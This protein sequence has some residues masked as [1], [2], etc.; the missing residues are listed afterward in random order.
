MNKSVVFTFRGKLASAD[1]AALQLR[2]EESVRALGLSAESGVQARFESDG[3]GV[4]EVTNVPQELDESVRE[5]VS[6]QI[7][8][9]HDAVI[10]E[11]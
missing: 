6:A 1:V 7:T 4:I 8:A 10:T 11:E 2:V 3:R 9:A 5:T